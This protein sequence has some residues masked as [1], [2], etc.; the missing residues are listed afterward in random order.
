M[1]HNIKPHMSK[2]MIRRCFYK[3]SCVFEIS[4]LAL[5]SVNLQT[6]T[7]YQPLNCKNKKRVMADVLEEKFHWSPTSAA[8]PQERRQKVKLKV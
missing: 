8:L 7:W 4:K 3:S 2:K 6:K 5:V 1:Q